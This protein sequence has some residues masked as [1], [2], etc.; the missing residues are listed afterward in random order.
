MQDSRKPT[1]PEAGSVAGVDSA[2]IA[3]IAFKVIGERLAS[4]LEPLQP[5]RTFK[6]HE[7]REP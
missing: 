5:T 6:P 7:R 1:L 4:I 3:Q 2:V